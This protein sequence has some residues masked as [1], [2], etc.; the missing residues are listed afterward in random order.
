[1]KVRDNNHPFNSSCRIIPSRAASAARSK[2]HLNAIYYVIVKGRSE[3]LLR[4]SEQLFAGLLAVSLSATLSCIL[5]LAYTTGTPS[6]GS[7]Q[8]RVFIFSLSTHP[9]LE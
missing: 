9:I 1:M 8:A 3:T 7:A 5:I 2:D 4:E 6:H